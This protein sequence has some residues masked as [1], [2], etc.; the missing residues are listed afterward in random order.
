MKGLRYGIVGTGYG[1]VLE[2][3]RI[4]GNKGPGHNYFAELGREDI[5]IISTTICQGPAALRLR[6]YSWKFTSPFVLLYQG[7]NIPWLL[8]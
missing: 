7:S 5:C 6:H 8:V 2:L 4:W 1:L 3:R